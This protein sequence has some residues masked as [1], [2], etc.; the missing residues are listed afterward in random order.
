MNSMPKLSVR[1]ATARKTSRAAESKDVQPSFTF[2]N[3]TVDKLSSSQT[4]TPLNEDG[5]PQQLLAMTMSPQ[6]TKS[7]KKS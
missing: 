3:P 7:R 2:R 6:V 5:N 4:L 1:N